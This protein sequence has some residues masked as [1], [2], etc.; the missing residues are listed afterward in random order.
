MKLQ[1]E[2]DFV[3]ESIQKNVKIDIP[4]YAKELK[5]GKHGEYKDFMTRLS[6]DILHYAVPV[7][8]ICEWYDRYNCTD[9]HITTL[10]KKVLSDLYPEIKSI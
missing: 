7:K 9:N 3:K 2:Y 8:V 10:A 5:D 1:A 6:W 4:Q